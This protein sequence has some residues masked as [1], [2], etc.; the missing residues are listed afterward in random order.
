MISFFFLFM[1]EYCYYYLN[2][3]ITKLSL[4]KDE[5]TCSRSRNK[6]KRQIWDLNLISLT[7]EIEILTLLFY[8]LYTAFSCCNY[9]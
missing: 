1:C 5:V 9:G 6:K 4:K 3:P 7:S 8:Y 2:F